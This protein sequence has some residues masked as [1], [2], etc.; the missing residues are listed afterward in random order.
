MAFDIVQVVGK[1]VWLRSLPCPNS[2]D[3]FLADKALP[4]L[5]YHPSEVPSPTCRELSI[6]L[7]SFTRILPEHQEDLGIGMSDG[8]DG[9]TT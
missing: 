1:T 3:P 8:E 2:C 5:L 9:I 7:L 6:V 4:L